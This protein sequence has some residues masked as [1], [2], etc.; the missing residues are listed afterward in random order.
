MHWFSCFKKQKLG[1]KHIKTWVKD[2]SW[3]RHAP[4]YSGTLIGTKKKVL[5]LDQTKIKLIS[6]EQIFKNKEASF[7]FMHEHNLVLFNDQVRLILRATN[8]GDGSYVCISKDLV[9]AFGD[10]THGPEARFCFIHPESKAYTLQDESNSLS[11]H[12]ITKKLTDPTFFPTK[13]LQTPSQSSQ[14]TSRDHRPSE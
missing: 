2:F 4:S 7:A 10:T 11:M 14:R 13:D 9:K 5:V 3:T 6:T 12:E 1:F 8:R